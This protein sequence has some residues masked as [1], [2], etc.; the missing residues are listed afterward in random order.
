MINVQVSDGVGAAV[1]IP[2][3]VVIIPT[4]PPPPV[5]TGA[6]MTVEKGSSASQQ[7]SGLVS[8]STT[9]KQALVFSGPT[10]LGNGL[11]GTLDGSVLTVTADPSAPR[12]TTSTATISVSDGTNPAVIGTIGVSIVGSNAALATLAANRQVEATAGQ[13]LT[14][15]VLDG[16]YNP[17]PD[18]PLTITSATASNGVPAQVAGASITVT[19]PAGV[20]DQF[21]VSFAVN[22]ATGDADRQV[23]GTVTVI[24]LAKPEAPTS[25]VA[26]SLGSP[27]SV[28]VAWRAPALV[29]PAIS[30]YT[31]YW[32]GGSAN[33]PASAGD[34]AVDGLTP[35][36]AYTFEVSATNSEGEGP[37]SAP[38]AEITPG[39]R[40]RRPGGPDRGVVGRRCG[41]GDVVATEQQG[42]GDRPLH[43]D[44]EYVRRAEDRQLGRG[45]I[46]R[47]RRSRSR[48]Q[49]SFTVSATNTTGKTSQ[50]SAASNS[51]YPSDVTL[52][53]GQPAL[54]RPMSTAAAPA[55]SRCP[56][57]S[58]GAHGDPADSY[59]V[60]VNGSSV[61]RDRADDQLR[62][63]QCPGRRGIRR[64]G[65]GG[66]SVGASASSSTS[67][68]TTNP[69]VANVI[70]APS[71]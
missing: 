15:P 46:R 8:T 24:P 1:F 67:T 29:R 56:G 59:S 17:F 71:R 35:G 33:C 13:P 43:L 54:S 11:S 7:L 44:P 32:A 12:G 61:H 41:A 38:S 66:Q 48:H 57:M 62:D 42:F 4:V 2:I 27:H 26:T 21:T 69:D 64:V 14:I 39:R 40:T 22:D 20:L 60:T 25:V 10:G 9:S 34:C 6:S 36:T 5:F 58:A 3:P 51:V 52:A 37:R 19:P 28:N 31:V 23:Q 45:N 65:E 63:R 68:I 70:S 50:N 18:T 30:G 47:R 16:A 55:R 49:V 53:P